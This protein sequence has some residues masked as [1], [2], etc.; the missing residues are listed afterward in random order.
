MVNVNEYNGYS[1]NEIIDNAIRNKTGDGIV[2]IPPRNSST[3]PE[4]DWWLLDRS[5][6][7][8]E[9]TTI[10]L[11]NCKIKLSDNCRD[12]FFRT[13]NCGIGISYPEEI[14]NVHIKGEGLCVLEGADHPRST[15]DASKMIVSPCPYETKDLFELAEW[16]PPEDKESGII[17]FWD[18]HNHTYGTDFGKQAESQHGDWRNIGI[19]FAN[20]S[21]FSIENIKIV[22][23]HGWGISLEACSYG[24]LKKIDF[25]ARMW[26]QIDGMKQNIENQDG[27]DIRN[28]CHD[29]IISDI[30]GHTGDDMVALTAIA[31]DTV[32]FGGELKNTHVMH[33][34][35]NM[36]DKDIHDIIIRNVKGYSSLCYMVRL[37]PVNTK[38]WNVIIDGVVDTSSDSINNFGCIMLGTADEGYGKNDID[39]M[40]NIAVTNV[41]SNSQESV[42]IAGYISDSVISNVIN[43]NPACPCISIRRENGMINVQISALCSAG[44]ETIELKDAPKEYPV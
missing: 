26:K 8:P 31:K 12:N 11:Q 15:G 34:D 6:I 24:E 20:A 3:E 32:R 2:I 23:S 36:R 10:V 43:R 17:K 42:V 27:I 5:I 18:R 13:A 28:G 30:T 29:I 44:S 1:D 37:L 21:N 9:N 25:D 40:K 14:K 38:I 4:R 22:E 16:I 41:I 39:G 19:L 35:W 7:I 33:T